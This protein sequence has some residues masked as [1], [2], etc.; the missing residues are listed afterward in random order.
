MTLPIDTSSLR[1]MC[2]L[3]PRVVTDEEVDESF[4]CPQCEEAIQ[5]A[6][7]FR[8]RLLVRHQHTVGRQ[9]TIGVTIV[10]SLQ[11]T[12]GSPLLQQPPPL[13]RPGMGLLE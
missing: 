2:A 13:P 10:W 12:I 11:E 3:S 8:R 4:R 9:R 5:A 6:I 7:L 1:F